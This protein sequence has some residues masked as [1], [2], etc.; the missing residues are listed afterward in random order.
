[1]SSLRRITKLELI[2]SRWIS[3]SQRLL[4]NSMRIQSLSLIPSIEFEGDSWRTW[5][6]SHPSSVVDD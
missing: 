1:M 2:K 5:N 6:R 4:H 3:P